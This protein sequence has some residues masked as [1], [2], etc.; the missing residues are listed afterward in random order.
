[1]LDLAL[2]GFVA[3][4]MVLGARRPF[5]WV[6]AYL[7]IDIVSPQTFSWFLL[8]SI[9]ISLITFVAAFGGWLVADDKADSRFSM[10]QGLILALLI[11]CGI[12]TLNA[13]FH[14]QALDKWAWVWKALL[15]AMFLPLT[16]RTRLRFE[17][18]A[19]VM[20]LSAGAIIIGGSIKTLA[21]GGGYGSLSLFVNNNTG[22]YE[23]SI[24]SCVSI[25]IIPL[26]VWLMKHGTIFPPEW[27]VR[28]FGIALIFACLL[29]PIGTQARTGL[30]CIV[31][32]ALLS[33]RTVK[34]R[35]LY[36]AM[37][38]AA[39]V[40]TVPFLPESYT[41]RMSTI[42]N[43]ESD[44]SASTRVAVWK[45]TIEYARDN[46]WGGG[47]MAYLG[48]KVR[49]ELRKSE[50]TGGQ[51]QIAT[52][53]VE[54]QARAFHSSYFEM[55]G[56]Q[57]YPGLILWLW[58]MVSGLWQMERLYRRWRKRTGPD[59]Q[60]QAPLAMALQQAQ[61]V[62]ML[63]SVFVGIAFQPFCYMLIGLQIGL[64]SYLKRIE[65]NRPEAVRQLPG[66]KLKPVMTPANVAKLEVP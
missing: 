51:T 59:E 58:L 17:A 53:D 34:R 21:T 35:F 47:F 61:L 49:V 38:G 33:L 30:L 43:H 9:P 32:L 10:R 20:V 36:L 39:V 1:M 40:V 42:E 57:G 25:A 26:I 48:N 64:W 46:P 31:L 12:T 22:L 55:L 54:D 4:L 37:A 14:E 23:S 28:L 24:I 62:Y 50:S 11:Y 3:I 16:L 13:E 45:W 2:G 56:E 41:A 60:W 6:L 63:G 5:L 44:Q 8:S 65:A 27:R 7:Y 18:V 29:I 66:L 15:F 52:D 19:L